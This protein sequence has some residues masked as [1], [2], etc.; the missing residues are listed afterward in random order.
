[1]DVDMDIYIY[2]SL[3]DLILMT[4]LKGERGLEN[5]K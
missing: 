1:M 2:D 3:N 5:E 4:F